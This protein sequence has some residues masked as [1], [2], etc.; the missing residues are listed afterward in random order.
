MVYLVATLFSAT[1]WTSVNRLILYGRD[2]PVSSKV[3]GYLIV[4]TVVVAM[5]TFFAAVLAAATIE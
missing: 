4:S 3:L 5:I 2:K 1:V